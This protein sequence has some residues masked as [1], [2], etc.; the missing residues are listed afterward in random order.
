MTS[1]ILNEF[2]LLAEIAL[3]TLPLVIAWGWVRW[4]RH[5]ATMTLFS[6]F[7]FFGFV[8]ATAS[9]LLAISTVTYASIT[10]S[11]SFYDPTLLKIY[12]VGML[13][14]LVGLILSIVGAF[15]ANSLR[16][17]APVCAFGT[18]F[19]WFMAAATE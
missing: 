14:S 6:A 13:L 10:N 16:Y 5:N 19:F 3:F 15:K 9:E 2:L 4:A 11:F 12:A 1:T 7:S 17:L 18:F 8:L